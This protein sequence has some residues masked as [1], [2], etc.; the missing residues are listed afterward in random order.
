MFAVVSVTTGTVYTKWLTFNHAALWASENLKGQDWKVYTLQ[1]ENIP[2]S[3][4]QSLHAKDEEYCEY[5]G[6]TPCAKAIMERR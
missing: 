5:C 6:T 3:N 2:D 4:Y 1:V